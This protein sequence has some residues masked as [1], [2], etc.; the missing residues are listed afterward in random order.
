MLNN[1]STAPGNGAAPDRP[2]V[3][4]SLAAALL[5]IF[6]AILM[7]GSIRRETAGFDEPTHI[8]AGVSYIQKLDLR[9]NPEHPP[10]AKI[11]AALP[12]VIHGVRAD[13]SNPAWTVSAERPGPPLEYIFGAALQTRWND[14]VKTLEWARAPMLLLTLALGWVVFTY[15]RRLGG[16]WGGLLCLSLYVSM[17]VFLAFGP[18]VLTDVAIT[19]FSLT[20]LWT[21]AEMWREP[22]RRNVRIFALN[23]TGALLSKFTAGILFFAFVAFALSTRWRVVAGQ[24]N[25]KPEARDWRRLRRRA[26]GRATLWA[27][28]AVYVIYFILSI[29]QPT[30]PLGYVAHGHIPMF[31]RR[32][33]LPAAL[34]L[35]GIVVVVAGGSRPT[36]LLSHAYK[37][38]MWFYFP[39]LFLFKSP[40]GF[41]ALLVLAIALA[42]Y[43]RRPVQTEA[44]AI[45]PQEFHLQWRVLWTSLV[46]FTAFCLAT[47]LN[48][49]YRH[50]SI[51][52]I[53]LILLMA[54]LPRMLKRLGA[55]VPAAARLVTSFA[56]LLALSCLVTAVHAYPFYMPYINALGLGHPVYTIAGKADVDWDQ[57]MPEVE[58]FAVEHGLQTIEVD[59]YGEIDPTVSVPQARLWNCQNPKPEDQGQWVVISANQILDAHNCKWIM[60]Y[61]HEALGGGSMYAIQLPAQIPPA[62]SAGGPPLPADQREMFGAKIDYRPFFIEWVNHPE[63][64]AAFVA[65]QRAE[66]NRAHPH[67]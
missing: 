37:H 60:A 17:P 55:S 50:F 43:L 63:K 44:P 57:A 2:S 61:P 1:S 16:D 21:F 25:T 7:G 20:T 39:V 29:H 38:G 3:F 46:V 15:G 23:L 54:P 42:L 65:E 53:L 26:T 33:L 13:Y 4:F 67:K 45:V 40:L 9:M 8:G 22:S 36:F 31:L 27:A 5:L 32:L 66:Y 48:I 49:G 19:L 64:F 52:L 47:R 30:T 24:P 58:R 34:Y 28:L 11:L 12:L 6:M 18:L 14:P 10:L 41:L 51:P 59:S 35:F 62:G 56:A